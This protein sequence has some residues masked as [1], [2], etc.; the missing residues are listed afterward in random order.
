MELKGIKLTQLPSLRGS[1]A[2][3]A[4]DRLNLHSAILREQVAAATT[5]SKSNDARRLYDNPFERAQGV[6]LRD[7]HPA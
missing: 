6:A 1:A 3:D 5:V 2:G 7:R 4:Q